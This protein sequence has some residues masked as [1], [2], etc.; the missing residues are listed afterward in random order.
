M[1]NMKMED[2]DDDMEPGTPVIKDDSKRDKDDPNEILLGDDDI[3]ED[4]V[5]TMEDY[6]GE[7]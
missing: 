4:D 2:E 1:S 6:Y 3:I 5:D 7:S